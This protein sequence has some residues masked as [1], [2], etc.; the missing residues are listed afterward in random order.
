MEG[1]C[2]DER[3]QEKGGKRTAG[4]TL[5]IG[6][7]CLNHIDTITPTL[8]PEYLHAALY[9]GESVVLFTTPV[10]RIY[11]DELLVRVPYAALHAALYHGLHHCGLQEVGPPGHAQVGPG[12]A[13]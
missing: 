10:P 7:K 12:L 9:H 8:L 1:E 5:L 3:V 13:A 6:L 2:G 4:K 11:L